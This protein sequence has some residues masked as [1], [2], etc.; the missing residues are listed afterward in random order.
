[1]SEASTT[2]VLQACLDRLRAGDNAA[3]DELINRASQRLAVL[4]H[5]MFGR[6]DGVRQWEQTDDVA[7]NAMMRLCRALEK[8]QPST[9]REFMGL[10]SLQIRRELTDLARHHG[11][12]G[13]HPRRPTLPLPV[14]RGSDDGNPV[15]GAAEPPDETYDPARLAL[16]AEFHKS[17]EALPEPERE[18]V[19]LLWYQDLSIQETAELLDVNRGTVRD[20]WRSARLKLGKALPSGQPDGERAV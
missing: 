20:R 11:G 9:V 12:R 10:A 6:H 1:M 7:Q 4:T 18:V 3:R 16:W 2:R 5:R 13:D 15:H 17:V 8:V 19:E 14:G